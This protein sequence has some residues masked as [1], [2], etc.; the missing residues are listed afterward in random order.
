MDDFSK[1]MAALE[2]ERDAA[3]SAGVPALR[4][5]MELAESRD[6]GQIG[7]VVRA[8]AGLYNGRR[9]PLDLTQLRG[10]DTDIFEDLIAVIRLDARA[11]K[12]EIHL[13]FE[14]GGPRLERLIA[15]W[16]LNPP[17]SSR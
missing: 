11:C 15:S 3:I 4:R 10:L 7:T 12:Q 1:K 9:F 5:L 2:A 16:S 17:E 14:N 13:Y 8:L 6:S